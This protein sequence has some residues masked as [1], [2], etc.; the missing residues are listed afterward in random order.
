MVAVAG[1]VFRLRPVRLFELGLL[2]P[3]QPVWAVAG[4]EPGLIVSPLS[5]KTHTCTTYSITTVSL[6]I[7]YSVGLHMHSRQSTDATYPHDY[8]RH[9][10]HY[11]L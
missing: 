5:K 11:T 4:L 6:L 3:D 9:Y 8:H 1:V 7:R 10:F 2:I